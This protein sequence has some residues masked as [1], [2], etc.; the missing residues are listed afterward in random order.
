MDDNNVV[1]MTV[2]CSHEHVVGVFID[3]IEE[4]YPFFCPACDDAGG[5]GDLRTAGSYPWHL[6][7]AVHPRPYVPP[8]S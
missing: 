1:V 2:Y 6:E 8:A 5:Y 3:T 4:K 7:T